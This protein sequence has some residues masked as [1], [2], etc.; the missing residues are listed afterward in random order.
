MISED[1]AVA[2]LFAGGLWIAYNG[3]NQSPPRGLFALLLAAREG[4]AEECRRL[5]VAGADVNESRV[6]INAANERYAEECRR[7]VVWL[8]WMEM[9]VGCT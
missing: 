7:L 9:K 5:A 6:D 3:A 4:H 8:E 1:G 2:L